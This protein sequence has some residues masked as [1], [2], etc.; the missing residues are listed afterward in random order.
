MHRLAS[1]LIAFAIAAAAC[2]GGSDPPPDANVAAMP[3]APPPDAT[4]PPDQYVPPDVRIPDDAAVPGPVYPSAETMLG[5]PTWQIVDWQLIAAPI[6]DDA[7][8][9]AAFNATMEA[10]FPPHTYYPAI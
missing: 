10:I 7:D 9:F 5:S 2:S 3:D 1:A 8:G 4:P 6:G